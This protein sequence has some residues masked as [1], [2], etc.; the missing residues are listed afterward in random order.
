MGIKFKVFIP[1]IL[2]LYLCSCSNSTV[3]V[4]VLRTSQF[5]I[6]QFDHLTTIQ[7]SESLLFRSV[8]AVASDNN[9]TIFIADPSAYSIYVFNSNGAHIQTLGGEGSGPG[10]FR[11]ILSMFV[12][13]NKQLFVNDVGLNRTNIFER[14]DYQWTFTQ[15]YT[16]GSHRY[17]VVSAAPSGKLGL[18]TSP[19][20]QPT[21]GA[22]WYVHDL[23]FGELKS[24]KVVANL[25][26]FK[27]RGQLVHESGGMIGI[28]FGRETLL[29]N[30]IYGHIYLLWTDTFEVAVYDSEINPIDS[31]RANLPNL[32]V[33]MQEKQQRI[34]RIMQM[35]HALAERYIPETKPVAQKLHVD[36][37]GRLWV[38]TFDSPEYLVLSKQGVGSASFDLPEN[39][40]LMYVDDT[41]LYSLKVDD[42][43]TQVLVYQYTLN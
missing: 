42:S 18:R 9:G 34:D 23:G 37:K 5:P 40:T 30:D 1:F 6:L 3:S 29:T 39:E 8:S 43:G 28:P 33:S 11:S 24:E 26:Q 27:Q 16:S 31:I 32:D 14:N 10:E 21:Q 13:S 20:Q 36:P 41:M 12:S 19:F 4:E 17:L 22:Y 38:Q 2:F 35:F 7:D 25:H 15:E